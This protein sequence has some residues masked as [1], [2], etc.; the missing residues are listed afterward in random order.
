[1]N[2]QCLKEPNLQSGAMPITLYLP[3]WS[4]RQ[5]SNL[6]PS[7][8]KSAAPPVVLRWHIVKQPKQ[9]CYLDLRFASSAF[10]F[11]SSSSRFLRFLMFRAA[12]CAALKGAGLKITGISKTSTCFIIFSAS[13]FQSHPG[14][15]SPPPSCGFGRSEMSATNCINIYKY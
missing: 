5:G 11:F 9:A 3:I 10:L 13:G 6:H 1:M 14:L 15:F 4:H 7:D 8:Y 2:Q 12:A